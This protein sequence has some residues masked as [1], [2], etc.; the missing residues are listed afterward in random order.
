MICIILRRQFCIGLF[1][2]LP[3]LKCCKNFLLMW[4]NTKKEERIDIYYY[5]ERVGFTQTRLHRILK[6]SP[7]LP[8][9]SS[10]CLQN[11]RNKDSYCTEM[12]W[13]LLKIMQGK[14]KMIIKETVKNLTM[15]ITVR[16]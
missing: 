12:S 16:L 9:V 3:T 6:V 11:E 8:K 15:V 7:R 4:Q 10:S 13:K 14:L 1:F 2:H 5:L